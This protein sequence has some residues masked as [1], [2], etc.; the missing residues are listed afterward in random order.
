MD[1]ASSSVIKY[2]F[3]AVRSESVSRPTNEKQPHLG[4]LT[5]E[6]DIEFKKSD[7]DILN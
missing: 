1:L 2:A 5:L 6:P 4:I 7:R 3:K